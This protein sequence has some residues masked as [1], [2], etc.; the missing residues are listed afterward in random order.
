MQGIIRIIQETIKD[1]TNEGVK[2]KLIEICNEVER[3]DEQLVT[4]GKIIID[5]LWKCVRKLKI[6]ESKEFPVDSLHNM[7]KNLEILTLDIEDKVD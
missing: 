6:E 7:M 3:K 4:T 5:K 1:M 2:L